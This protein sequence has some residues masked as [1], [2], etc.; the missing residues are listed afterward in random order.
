MKNQTQKQLKLIKYLSIKP[1]GKSVGIIF[2]VS[3]ECNLL[4]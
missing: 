1:Y 2:S 3:I 4:I